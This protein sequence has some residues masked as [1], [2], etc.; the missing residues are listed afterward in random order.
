VAITLED[1]NPDR[2]DWY[3]LGL[4]L[5]QHGATG[6]LWHC[7]GVPLVNLPYCADYLEQLGC[8]RWLCFDAPFGGPACGGWTFLTF[9][10]FCPPGNGCPKT[11]RE[12]ID[13]V[14]K[15]FGD[16]MQANQDRETVRLSVDLA[17]ELKVRRRAHPRN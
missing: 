3:A 9:E 8:R 15:C 4:M 2:D 6:R 11:H 14:L 1:L 5:D 7:L 13:A 12:D 16:A 10:P 17:R